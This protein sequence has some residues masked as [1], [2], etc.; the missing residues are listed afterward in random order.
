MKKKGFTLVELLAVIIILGVIAL[1]TFP[2]VD[3]SIKNS[4]QAALEQ[5]IDSILE[6]ARNYSVEYDL[7]YSVEENAIRLDDLKSSGFLTTDITNP[8]TNEKMTGC[9]LYKWDEGS[10]QYI[11]RYDEECNVK[12]EYVDA[13]GANKPK[14]YNN[15]IPVRYDGNNWVYADLYEK[16]YDY[17]N[18]EWA[19]AV[20]LNSG[21]TKNVGDIITEDEIALWYVW[22][23]RYTYTIFNGND[24][25]I[26][27]QL[28]DI[29]FESSTNSGGTIVCVDSIV[30]NVGEESNRASEICTDSVN[31]SIIDGTS[32]YTHPA[33]TFGDEELTGFWV[34]KFEVSTT[35]TTC[36]TTSNS[37]NCNKVLPITIK[38]GVSSFRN[39]I[40]SNF[41]N[42]I[43]EIETEYGIDADS[44]VIKN[45][46]W[47]AVSYL[48]QSQY[49]LGITDI[50]VN[51]SSSFI[52]GGGTSVAY[53]TNTN[54][55]TTGNIYGVYDMSG[56]SYE[57][58][59]T[60]M[61]DVIYGAFNA[62]GSGFTEEPESK[63]LDKYSYGSSSTSYTRGKLGDATKETL[64]T[65]GSSTGGWYSNY[66]NLFWSG[67]SWL[68][69]GGYSGSQYSGLF[70]SYGGSTGTYDSRASTRAI[71]S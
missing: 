17:S 52:T 40:L 28:I 1:I 60:T 35:D 11:F 20:V 64:A 4:K 55:S 24:G 22:I 43:K 8:I 46:E 9:V 15:M 47:G 50:E 44:H 42:S 5:T 54:Q 16:W 12:V 6:S 56:N 69:R 67:S 33:F 48:K 25:S 29:Q 18:K 51:N 62:N 13:S 49:G 65:L 34:G 53:K 32:T 26:P 2:I 71:L 45:K 39:A 41:F 70:N 14:L 61:V 66:F 7:G 63:Y 68:L 31:G 38:P 57:Y 3:N 27:E 10:N 19:N 58:T 59:M 21:V 23:P 36:N 37:T 30:G